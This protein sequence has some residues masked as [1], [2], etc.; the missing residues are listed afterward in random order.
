MS[1]LKPSPG[2]RLLR[3]TYRR[4]PPQYVSRRAKKRHNFAS[5][6]RPSFI[7]VFARRHCRRFKMFF[8]SRSDDNAAE[9]QNEVRYRRVNIYY[10]DDCYYL[11]LAFGIYR[12][13]RLALLRDT[14][15]G[16]LRGF[17]DWL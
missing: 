15:L 14:Q 6:E 3:A 9:I 7:Y 16:Y 2:E 12:Y 10:D 5:D 4:Q 11:Q 17:S 13:H 8:I 1:T